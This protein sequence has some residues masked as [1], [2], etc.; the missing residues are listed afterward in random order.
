MRN[1]I[2]ALAMLLP[3]IAYSQK[4]GKISG[5]VKHADS[6]VAKAYVALGDILR[7]TTNEEGY[8]EFADVAYGRYF[9]TVTFAGYKEYTRMVILNSAST[10]IRI[11]MEDLLIE[12]SKVFVSD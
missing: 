4:T 9:L 5:Y 6:I 10:A 3:V 2:F 1:L 12:L 8:F 7:T 11:D